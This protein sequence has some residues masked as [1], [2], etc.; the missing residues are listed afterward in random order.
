RHGYRHDR[1]ENAQEGGRYEQGDDRQAV[2]PRPAPVAMFTRQVERAHQGPVIWATMNDAGRSLVN[3]SPVRPG[4]IGESNISTRL[5]C[6]GARSLTVAVSVS[7]GD[8]SRPSAWMVTVNDPTVEVRL[9]TT[10]DRPAVVGG[11][12][13]SPPSRKS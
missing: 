6:P 5:D 9:V 11:I 7:M 12:S 8:R 13:W 4:S 1:R 10:T 2:S 3:R